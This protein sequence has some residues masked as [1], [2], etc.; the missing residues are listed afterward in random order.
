MVDSSINSLNVD[1]EAYPTLLETIQSLGREY[2]SFD[3]RSSNLRRPTGLTA[4]P[5][6]HVPLQ[7]DDSTCRDVSSGQGDPDQDRS[8]FAERTAAGARASTSTY[9]DGP[10]SSSGAGGEN[11]PPRDIDAIPPLPTGL[12]PMPY[13]KFYG[14]G[15]GGFTKEFRAKY[16]IPEDVLVERVF[17]DRISFDEDFIVLPLF[18]ITEGRGEHLAN[19]ML[20]NKVSRVKQH[21]IHPWGPD[22][23]VRRIWNPKYDKYYLTTRQHFD[24]LVDRLYDTE[25]WGNVLV[26]VSGNFEWGPINPLLDYPCPT[27]TGS[28][29]ERPYK[30]PRK[31]GFPRAGD[32]LDCSAPN[33][34]LFVTGKWTNLIALLRCADR[35]APTLL[36]Y[37]PTY[38]GFAHRKNKENMVRKTFDLA[39]AA[40]QALQMQLQAQDLS[41]SGLPER[42]E[43]SEAAPA[44][45]TEQMEHPPATVAT[46]KPNSGR[47]RNVRPAAGGE[48]QG[49][50]KK[51]KVTDG[52]EVLTTSHTERDPANLDGPSAPFMPD[53]ECP[54]GHLIT[55]GDSLEHSPL[56]AM[57]LLKGLALPRDMDNL[58]TGKAKTMAELCLHLAKCARK[59]FNDMDVLLE[60]NRSLRGDL[61][62][63]RKEME[64]SIKEIEMLEAKVAEGDTVQQERDQLLLQIKNAEEENARLREEKV[65]SLVTKAFKKG[66][67]KGIKDTHH[68]SFLRGYQVGLD[69]AEISEADHRREPPVVLVP[70]EQSK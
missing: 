66:E 57:T 12:E 40:R 27:R 53:F 43:P 67:L 44:A 30:I 70:E 55:V 13:S 38:S 29:V 11:L 19:P 36:D 48:G 23:D 6:I 61:Q 35:D 32:K 50:S 60:T 56:L 33:K 46:E 45:Q 39:T 65:Q 21:P 2:R 51:A 1:L 37:E 34:G 47:Q 16:S 17:G 41:T 59:A 24:H 58:P 26:K 42:K 18:A 22:A 69:Y 31:R 15:L 9:S 5:G 20:G 52:V 28:A 64:R 10:P 62:A 68:S 4:I 8:E 14:D 49:A 63:Q 7:M 25:K 54:V 3:E